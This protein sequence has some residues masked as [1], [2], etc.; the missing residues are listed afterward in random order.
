M[1]IS[2]EANDFAIEK[3]VTIESRDAPLKYFR[4]NRIILNDDKRLRS[5]S[6][7]MYP[8]RHW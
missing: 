5:V 7:K 8:N 3:D 4:T 1:P 2:V 6:V